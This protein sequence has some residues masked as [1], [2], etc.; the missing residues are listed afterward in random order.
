MSD[1]TR[2]SDDPLVCGEQVF[3]AWLDLVE[4]ALRRLMETDD[5]AEQ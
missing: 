3:R 4:R 1:R 5:G 2:D